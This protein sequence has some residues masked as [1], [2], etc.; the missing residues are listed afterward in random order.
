M[1]LIGSV[2]C[3]SLVCCNSANG[4]YE[5]GSIAERFANRGVR[6]RKPRTRTVAASL[7]KMEI[8]DLEPDF[9]DHEL[10][11]SVDGG[12]NLSWRDLNDLKDDVADHGLRS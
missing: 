3:M 7:Q 5:L 1:V 9:E 2:C 12:D 4:F 11:E 10:D 6:V 8:P